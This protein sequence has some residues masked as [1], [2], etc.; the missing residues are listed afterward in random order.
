MRSPAKAQST[1]AT[2]PTDGYVT[3]HSPVVMMS[4]PAA[5]EAHD[6]PYE[7]SQIGMFRS[8][9]NRVAAEAE[10]VS[11]DTVMNPFM[12][13]TI[14]RAVDSRRAPQDP[15]S[16]VRTTTQLAAYNRARALSPQMWAQPRTEVTDEADESLPI[17]PEAMEAAEELMTF[18]MSSLPKSPA[19]Y[20][21]PGRDQLPLPSP[22][23]TMTAESTVST[24][25]PVGA[26][27]SGQWAPSPATTEH[28]FMQ[29][30]WSP[31]V[32]EPPTP[33]MSEQGT[34]GVNNVGSSTKAT[35]WAP[36]FRPSQTTVSVYPP[37][38]IS[39]AS[40]ESPLRLATVER[41]DV[42][43]TTESKAAAFYVPLDPKQAV[44]WGPKF[45]TP[46]A[47]SPVAVRKAEAFYVSLSDDEEEEREIIE[48]E[49]DESYDIYK[50]DQPIVDGRFTGELPN[51]PLQIVGNRVPGLQAMS[52]MPAART[53]SN[54]AGGHAAATPA[55]VLDDGFK[56]PIRTM[57]KAA[58]PGEVPM[59]APRQGNAERL[60]Q[61]W[62]PWARG[63]P[64]AMD[65][66]PVTHTPAQPRNPYQRPAGLAFPSIS[67]D[68]ESETN[69]PAHFQA[70]DTLL[71]SFRGLPSSPQVHGRIEEL[72]ASPEN[73]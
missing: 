41:V 49:V 59:T 11:P 34:P 16:A 21:T 67:E 50:V 2:E 19:L 12:P 24:Q 70:Q 22:L 72:D 71:N 26:S 54:S 42:S 30:A 39:G 62:S 37:L 61:F 35:S 13:T 29:Q 38:D 73:M 28:S 64:D 63:A 57:K 3:I 52:P 65:Y 43:T 17:G 69:R 36:F 31:I 27:E 48:P 33:N 15:V 23:A 68:T 4:E 44:E 5:G 51:T 55:A 60:L 45:F 8:P 9:I 10:T 66:D 53:P 32:N 14:E 47:D 56:R 6:S 46:A 40:T 1:E 25:T 58:R 7:P 18:M 20:G